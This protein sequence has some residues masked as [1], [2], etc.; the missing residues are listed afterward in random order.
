MLRLWDSVAGS[1][2]GAK[3]TTLAHRNG[4]KW[5]VRFPGEP[6]LPERVPVSDLILLS[7][8]E[9]ETTM[10]R[11]SILEVMSGWRGLVHL[12]EA[13]E[14]LGLVPAIGDTIRR[15]F[16]QGTRVWRLNAPHDLDKVRST[17]DTILER[18]AD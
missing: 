6:A 7:R 5:Y 4:Q 18:L 13:M 15:M 17:V 2:I 9:T 11:A 14:R 10:S 1:I 3:R 8:S 16:N 12:P